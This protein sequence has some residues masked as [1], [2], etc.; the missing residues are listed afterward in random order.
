MSALPDPKADGAVRIVSWNVR[1]GFDGPKFDRLLELQPDVA[2][3]PESCT[4]VRLAKKRSGWSSHLWIGKEHKPT[5]GLGVLAF[6]DWSLESLEVDER[7]ERFLPVRVDGPAGFT[8]L[9]S[10]CRSKHPGIDVDRPKPL[11]QLEQLP[12]VYGHLLAAGP[13]VV[14]GDFNH[15]A[16]FDLPAH[17]SWGAVNA[18]FERSGL[19]SAYHSVTGEAFGA[20]SASTFF[21]GYRVRRAHHIDYCFVP[22]DWL[23]EQIWVGAY[24]DWVRAKRG[25]DHAPLVVDARPPAATPAIG[26]RS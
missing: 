4:P 23:V 15:S 8:L 22:S 17:R 20:E 12:E 13:T 19:K 2:V 10:W 21:S 18:S 11:S 6:G 14:A 5:K 25:S 16:R 3:V 9:A 26:G 7:L 1:E 24:A